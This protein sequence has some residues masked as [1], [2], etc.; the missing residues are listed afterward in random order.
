MEPISKQFSSVQHMT[1]R[2]SKRSK[3]RKNLQEEKCQSRR[4]YRKA[5]IRRQEAYIAG[6]TRWCNASAELPTNR[7]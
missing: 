1:V 4:I 7:Q 2:C 5:Q 6:I 3:I